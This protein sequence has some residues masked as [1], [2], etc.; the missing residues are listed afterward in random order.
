[1]V[2]AT[3]VIS[4]F[5]VVIFGFSVVIFGFSVVMNGS[6]TRPEPGSDGKKSMRGPDFKNISSED[7]EDSS[8]LKIRKTQKSFIFDIE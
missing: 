5:S 2:G 6:S 8:S 3:V 1:M 7:D 4:E